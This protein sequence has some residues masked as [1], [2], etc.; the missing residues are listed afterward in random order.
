MLSMRSLEIIPTS[1]FIEITGID[2]KVS[3][4]LLS[5][6]PGPLFSYRIVGL[7]AAFQGF[8]ELIAFDFLLLVSEDVEKPFPREPWCSWSTCAMLSL[9]HAGKNSGNWCNFLKA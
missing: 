3:W 5:A 7:E 2:F 8:Y 6:L 1:P 9:I 4:S